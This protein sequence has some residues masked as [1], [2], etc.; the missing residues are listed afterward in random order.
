MVFPNM[1]FKL[2]IRLCIFL[3]ILPILHYTFASV[4]FSIDIP[5]MDQWRWINKL[6]DYDNGILEFI[7]F[8]RQDFMPLGHSHILTMLTL[9]ANYQLFD[10]RLDYEVYFGIFFYIL[11]GCVLGYYFYKTYDHNRSSLLFYCYLLILSLVYF[12][13]HTPAIFGWSIL[14]F[15]FIYWLMAL[16]LAILFDRYLIKSRYAVGLFSWCLIVLFLGDAMGITGLLACIAVSLLHVK[17]LKRAKWF[18]LV[19]SIIIVC[20]LILQ[21]TLLSPFPENKI[22]K[23]ES[24]Y[25]CFSNPG[26]VLEFI[27]NAYSKS[28]V[29]LR[30]SRLFS[31]STQVILQ[32]SV[33]ICAL[34]FNFISVV[35]Y[36][37]NKIYLRTTIPLFLIMFSVISVLGILLTRLPNFGPEHAF[38]HRYIRLFVVGYLGCIWVIADTQFSTLKLKGNDISELYK[39]IPLLIA[40]LLIFGFSTILTWRSADSRSLYHQKRAIGIYQSIDNLGH[41]ME[42]ENMQCKNHYCD[43]GI[44]FLK[45]NKL[46]LFRDDSPYRQLLNNDFDH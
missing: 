28:V 42:K 7:D 9:W 8:V 33:G 17:V 12:C 15:E 30:I 37:R 29:D 45:N 19:V 20:G 24:L 10:L 36:F 35:I 11:S 5:R 31:K 34:L 22:S 44:M 6:A 14:S 46:S 3:A 39:T 25:Y 27:I 13:I 40:S 21:H 16:L 43:R 32:N 26:L 4:M 1:K 2:L 38:S 18:L 23:L 41:I